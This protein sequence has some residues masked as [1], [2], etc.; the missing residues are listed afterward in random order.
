MNLKEHIKA[1]KFFLGYTEE[2]ED[3]LTCIHRWIDDLD[4][5]KRFGPRH[6]I[7]NHVSSFLDLINLSLGRDAF[8]VALLHLLIDFD[9]M[10]DR[11]DLIKFFDEWNGDL[12]D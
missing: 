8:N 10:I 3:F 6:R 9:I 5:F 2:D 1:D 7:I 12:N 4:A 11:R